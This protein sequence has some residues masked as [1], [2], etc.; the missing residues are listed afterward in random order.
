M[1]FL[2]VCAWLFVFA[3]LLARPFVRSLVRSFVCV[4]VCLCVCLFVCFVLFC[5]VF[6]CLCLVVCA[7]AK[8]GSRFAAERQ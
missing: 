1:L 6:V 8:N 4:F 7:Q 3:C 5:F 2:F